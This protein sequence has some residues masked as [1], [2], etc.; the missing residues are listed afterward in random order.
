MSLRNKK[1]TSKSTESVKNN[2]EEF[3]NKDDT[4]DDTYNHLSRDNRRLNEVKQ[5]TENT[6]D[7]MDFEDTDQ[8]DKPEDKEIILSNSNLNKQANDH[9][10]EI[11]NDD[12]MDDIYNHLSRDNRG[13]NEEKPMTEN[14]YDHVDKVAIAQ[15][16]GDKHVAL[17]LAVEAT[18]NYA[19][20]TL[21]SETKK[22]NNDEINNHIIATS[23]A[24]VTSNELNHGHVGNDENEVVKSSPVAVVNISID[25]SNSGQTE[26][27]RC[28]GPQGDM[29]TTVSIRR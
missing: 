5:T 27:A 1:P 2:E 20:V 8:K 7:C 4:E 29:Y 26:L 13:Y 19:D 28:N 12:G 25:G 21:E 10:M 18:G 9:K 15:R 3:G 16:E 11:E 24:I 22:K 17:V 14:A 6:Y 23:T